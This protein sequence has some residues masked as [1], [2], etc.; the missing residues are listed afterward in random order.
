MAE[1][2][3]SLEP[4]LTLHIFTVSAAMVGVCL[5]GIGLFHAYI[6]EPSTSKLADDFLALD[7]SL[8]AVAC[9][10][11]F[12]S[13][14]ARLR[15]LRRRLRWVAD[16]LFLAGLALMVAVCLILTYDLF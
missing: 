13:F 2:E 6:R 7:A 10:L 3:D 14:R 16:W 15:R 5:T 12:L 9:C 1:E 4:V 8:F 11:S